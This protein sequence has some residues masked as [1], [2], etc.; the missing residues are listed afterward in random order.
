MEF[1]KV[2]GTN[3]DLSG[4]KGSTLVLPTS[5]AGGSAM[6][7]IDMY[8]LNGGVTKLG[9]IKSDMFSPSVINDTLTVAGAPTG[10]VQMP[11]E[12]FL[13]NDK[14]YTFIV[15][16]GGV[17]GGKMKE[18]GTAFG[19]FLMTVGFTDIKVLTATVSP[20][21]RERESNRQIP[22]IFAY[23]NN[24]LY[25]SS[26]ASGKSFYDTHSIKKFGWWLGADKRKPHQELNEMMGT[27]AAK[28]LMKAFNM[29]EIPVQMYIIFTPGGVDFVG[30]YTYYKFLQNNFAQGGVPVAGKPLGKVE[31][32]EKD[33][34]EV[35]K[36]VFESGTVKTPVHWKQIINYF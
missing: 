32:P 16:R 7:A 19:L 21:K 12:I 18:F 3:H 31:L 15:F 13:T 29:V 33:G 25:K 30:G 22:E 28:K 9:Y 11:V 36:L 6:L 14:K 1:V 10:Q 23:I 27:G 2:F 24:N 20:V 17:S 4:C 5:S 26:I 35:H 34:E 8:I